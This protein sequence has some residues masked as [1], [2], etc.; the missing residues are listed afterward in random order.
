[1]EILPLVI[2]IGGNSLLALC[3]ILFAHLLVRNLSKPAQQGSRRLA[4][5]IPLLLLWIVF[6]PNTSYLLTEWRHFLDWVNAN[7]QY[8]QVYRDAQYPPGPTASLLT[9]ALCFF[10]FSS[11]G[12][13]TLCLAVHPLEAVVPEK[14]RKGFKTGAF[15][16]CSF[17]TYLGL[18][19]RLNSFEIVRLSTLR[20][21][22]HGTLELFRHPGLAIT[23]VLFGL[24]LWGVYEILTPGII[25]LMPKYRRAAA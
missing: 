13:V 15:I 16:L 5:I 11:F 17:G 4:V 9:L 10:L 18:V 2:W 22:A 14:L 25:R 6:L 24:L 20:G 21:I 19:L 3:P 8:E 1:M 23:V 7:P 12:I